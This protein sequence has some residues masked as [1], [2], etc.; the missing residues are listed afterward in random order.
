MDDEKD[1]SI[2]QGLKLGFS[3]FTPIEKKSFFIFSI[4]I[5]FFSLFEILALLSLMPLI[6]IIIEYYLIREIN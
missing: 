1:I 3:L 5:S 4:L 6:A 2:F